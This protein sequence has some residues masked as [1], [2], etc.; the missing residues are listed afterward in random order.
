M[1][2]A[3][4]HVTHQMYF[5]MMTKRLIITGIQSLA[6]L[7]LLLRCS[8]SSIPSIAEKDKKVDWEKIGPGGG[9]ATF[10]P[11]FSYN[12]DEKFFVRC[13]MTGSY[14]TNDGGQ[15]FRQINFDNGVSSF[16]FDAGDSN[17]IY[18][19]SMVLNQSTDGGKTWKILFPEKKDIVSEAYSGD[20]AEY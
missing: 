10:I 15:S 8:N 14:L 12:N 2:S 3:E 5:M 19:G 4:R 7:L 17:N 11:T 1:D 6:L 18:V 9:G 20:H 13:D 16:A